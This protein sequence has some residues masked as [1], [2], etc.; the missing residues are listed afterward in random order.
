MDRAPSEFD[1]YDDKPE[2][3][4]LAGRKVSEPFGQ[5]VTSGGAGGLFASQRAPATFAWGCTMILSSSWALPRPASQRLE[6]CAKRTLSRCFVVG[7]GQTMSEADQEQA[8]EPPSD[9]GPK[10]CEFHISELV[11]DAKETTIVPAGEHYRL[12][13]TSNNKLILTK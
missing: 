8:P 1:V 11:G 7:K 6:H 13:V 4:R 5:I 10:A 2:L 9:A 3:V 12:C